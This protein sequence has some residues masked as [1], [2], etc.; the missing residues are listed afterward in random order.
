MRT[1]RVC[2]AACALAIWA[3]SGTAYAGTWTNVAWSTRPG[4]DGNPCR[5]FLFNNNCFYN[6]DAATDSPVLPSGYK[7]DVFVWEVTIDIVVDIQ[8][9]D[10]AGTL[11]Q[12]LPLGTDISA[13][14][15]GP[16]D[17]HG[18][19]KVN[20]ETCTTCEGE[21]MVMCAGAN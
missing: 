8:T 19:I 21:V 20:V 13:T 4:G 5:N 2:V 14:G 11:C 1:I 6:F 18:N 17:G 10:A 3:I 15:S 12:D 16:Q 7:C 9:C